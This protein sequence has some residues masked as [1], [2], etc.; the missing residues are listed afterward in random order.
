MG[1]TPAC[2]L[3]PSQA[4]AEGLV[5]QMMGTRGKRWVFRGKQAESVTSTCK[6]IEMA[7]SGFVSFAIEAISDSGPA[8]PAGRRRSWPA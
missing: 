5:G 3:K 1:P 6:Q 4:I 8:I 2:A 7:R